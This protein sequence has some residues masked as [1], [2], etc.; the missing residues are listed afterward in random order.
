MRYAL[1]TAG[2]VEQVQPIQYRTV[3]VEGEETQEPIPVNGFIEVADTVVCGMI[4][5]EDGTF[6]NPPETPE[7]IVAAKW[8]TYAEY[9]STLT[10]AATSENIF[11]ADTEALKNVAFKRDAITDTAR[12]LWVES[13]STFTTDKVELQ[14]VISEADRLM[15][16][17]I[18][19][20]FKVV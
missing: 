6:S 13:W 18:V 2:I 15:Q 5:N 10:V 4:V 11:A 20:L 16:L 12:I 19:E 9:C 3:I 7:S 14:E 8:T 17:K 1:I